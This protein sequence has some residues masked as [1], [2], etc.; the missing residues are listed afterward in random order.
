MSIK[1]DPAIVFQYSCASNIKNFLEKI[2]NAS[3]A[4]N[5]KMQLHINWQCNRSV[6]Q[7]IKKWQESL[8]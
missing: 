5:T 8:K 2:L 4:E 1:I 3:Y 7:K 6:G